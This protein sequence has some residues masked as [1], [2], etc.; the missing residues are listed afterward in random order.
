MSTTPPQAT[1]AVV[2]LI[3]APQGN[4]QAIAA[5]IVEREL[6]ACV[7][8]L[9]SV[10]SVYRWEGKVEQDEVQWLMEFAG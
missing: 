4:A 8:I 10:H 6:A 2:C 9:P 3:T 1:D 5:T 7:N